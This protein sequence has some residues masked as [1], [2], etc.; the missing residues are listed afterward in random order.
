MNTRKKIQRFNAVSEQT[1]IW[2]SESKITWTSYQRT[3]YWR[4]T[5]DLHTRVSNVCAANVYNS[6]LRK[7]LPPFQHIMSTTSDEGAW[8]R[9]R[10]RNEKSCL[11]RTVIK[12][13]RAPHTRST[14]DKHVLEVININNQKR[15]CKVAHEYVSAFWYHQ[16]SNYYIL[17]PSKFDLGVAFLHM[18]GTVVSIHD[19]RAYRG[20]R[21]I[22]PLILNLGTGCRWE[23]NHALA[24]L[25]P[26]KDPGTNWIG[27]WG[28]SELIRTVFEK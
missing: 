3:G 10:N 20:S 8:P 11:Y 16:N 26:G 9:S 24:A 1:L 12:S 17:Q 7:K 4:K 15:I 6:L 23:A 25:S 13:D 18:K 2:L 19:M 22:S 28:A 21:G 5:D 14:S 27:G